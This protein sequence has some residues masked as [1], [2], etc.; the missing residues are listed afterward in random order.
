MSHYLRCIQLA[1]NYKGYKIL[2]AGSRK[3][4]NY[5][6]KAGYDLFE[7]EDFDPEYVMACARKFSFAWLN[8]ND[9]D[10]IYLS[11]LKA[12]D[13]YKPTMVIGDMSPTLKMAAEKSGVRHVSLMNAY[14]SKFY[15]RT[16][17]LSRTHP[18]Y[19]HLKKLPPHLADKITDFAEK[20]AFKIVHK[21]FKMLRR[22]YELKKVKDHLHEME[23]DENLLCD[24]ITLFPQK[25]LPI[26]YKVIGPL[27]HSSEQSE[28][29]LIA[30]L[31]P[32]KTTVCICMGSTGNWKQ[33]S[34]LIDSKYQHLNII[35]A[36]DANGIIKG[37]NIF[38]REFVNL[39]EV[40]PF[41]KYLIC[42]GGNGTIYKGIEHQVFM[43]CITSHFE[44]EWNVQML[45]K[46]KLGLSVTDDPE[47]ELT[48][49]LLEPHA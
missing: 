1:S 48:K 28:Y 37:S 45:E 30:Q 24:D 21:P 7:V 10:R 41:C 13:R 26:N 11:Q 4:N 29:E 32:R 33:L 46:L 5:V 9:I 38:A 47:N 2:F 39:D 25:E 14:L 31:D 12:I 17:T 27:V 23:G 16:R 36:G 22:K 49:Y 6:K 34:F 3:Y 43:L 19:P 15:V 42:H 8:K 35:T 18:G 40:L 20:I 44:Q